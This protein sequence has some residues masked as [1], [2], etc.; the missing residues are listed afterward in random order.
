[1]GSSA[2]DEAIYRDMDARNEALTELLASNVADIATAQ[3]L[4][5]PSCFCT[6]CCARMRSEMEVEHSEDEGSGPEEYHHDAV[7]DDVD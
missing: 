3:R 6:R 1:M 5:S 4:E 7:D 2:F